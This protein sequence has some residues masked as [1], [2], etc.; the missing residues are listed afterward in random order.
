M[1][2]TIGPGG[3]GFTFLN[4]SISFL[5]GDATY[6]TLENKTINVDIH[7][8]NKNTAHEFLKDH[9]FLGEQDWVNQAHDQ[10]IIYVVPS[11]RDHFNYLLTISS[12]K[13]IFDNQLYQKEVLARHC[14]TVPESKYKKLIEHLSLQYNNDEVKKVF[15]SCAQSFI[16]H[17]NIPNHQDILLINYKEIFEN[18]DQKILQI[19]EFLGLTIDIDRWHTWETIYNQYQNNNQDYLLNFYT[20]SDIIGNNQTAILK[21]IINWKNGSY[22]IPCDV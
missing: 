13:I 10:S 3:C 7:P 20:E 17:Y 8:L 15:L 21:E 14:Y 6:K 19:F 9:V 4:W 16:G 2:L 12:K 1:I 18:L 22:Q 5:R 11:G